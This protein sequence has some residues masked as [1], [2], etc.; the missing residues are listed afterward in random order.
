MKSSG[1]VGAIV[2]VPGILTNDS[3]LHFA[4]F[5]L[6]VADHRKKCSTVASIISADV[7]F[8]A[9]R[10]R[11]YIFININIFINVYIIMTIF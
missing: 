4:G 5:A 11:I 1:S 10:V 6:M 7:L 2:D 3:D 9:M 8:F